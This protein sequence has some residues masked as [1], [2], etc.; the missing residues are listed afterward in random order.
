MRSRR[1]KRHRHTAPA[2]RFKLLY[3]KAL[4]PPK[5]DGGALYDVD[6]GVIDQ[7]VSS[8]K[9]K[10]TRPTLSERDIALDICEHNELGRIVPKDG[11]EDQAIGRLNDLFTRSVAQL[12]PDLI[13]KTFR[14][15]DAVFFAGQLFKYVDVRWSPN[16]THMGVYAHV[17]HGDHG[18]AHIIMDANKCFLF[19]RQK[20]PYPEIFETLLH[21]MTVGFNS[22]HISDAG[23]ISAH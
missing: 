18:T 13:Y 9:T 7:V 15:L 22:F 17:I 20:S 6:Q 14:D 23:M 2:G 16:V 5:A 11:S 8:L 21:E 10:R 3:D 4:E 12:G 19:C 1:E